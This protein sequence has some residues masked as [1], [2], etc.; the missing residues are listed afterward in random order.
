M[1]LQVQYH[2]TKPRKTKLSLSYDDAQTEKASAENR[3][4]DDEYRWAGVADPKIALTTSRSPSPRL[5]NFASEMKHLIPNSSRMNRGSNDINQ[6]VHFARQE[7]FSDLI[8]L[9][10]TRGRP[11]GM[12]VSHLPYGPTAYFTLYNVMLRRDIES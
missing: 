2:L 6:L 7:N 5:K 11:D 9:H 4:Q 8:I 12:I 1:L 3:S 10:E